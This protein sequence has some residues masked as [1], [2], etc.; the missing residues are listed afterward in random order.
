MSDL[1]CLKCK[2]YH[3]HNNDKCDVLSLVPV[4]RRCRT[5]ADKLYSMGIELFGVANF[6]QLAVDSDNK[7]IINVIVE[8]RH[9]YQIE[10]LDR[11]PKKW[12]VYTETYSDDH[13][14]LAVPILAYYETYCYDGVKSAD[15]KVKE[16]VDEFTQYLDDNFDAE[17][18]KA[19]ITLMCS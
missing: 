5:L 1:Y 15:D 12:R 18:V 10:L 7:Y 8:L 4:T 14:P 19:I 13:T 3:H 6:T 17:A 2:K 9:L 16:I 11:L